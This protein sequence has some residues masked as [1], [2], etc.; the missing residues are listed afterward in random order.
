MRVGRLRIA[1][2]ERWEA[3]PSG[4]L[5]ALCC[6]TGDG[7]DLDGERR[8]LSA[9]DVIFIRA[10]DAVRLR[11]GSGGLG[12]FSVACAGA[13]VA[14]LAR[15]WPAAWPWRSGGPVPRVRLPAPALARLHGWAEILEWPGA[16]ALDRDAFL[17]DLLRLAR[18]PGGWPG[19]VPPWL[20]EALDVFADPHHLPGGIPRLAHLCDRS[21]VH[22]N[23][24][25]RQHLG[26]TATQTVNRIRLAWA[27][28]ALRSSER[29][30]AAIALDCGL[31]ARSQF[32]RMF[33]QAYGMPPHAYRTASRGP[34]P[35]NTWTTTLV[36]DDFATPGWQARWQAL[37]APGHRAFAP[38]HGWLVSACDRAAW[39]LL[40]ERLVP[41]WAVEYEARIL[42][43]AQPGDLSLCWHGGDAPPDAR[44]LGGGRGSG[45]L[46]LQIGAQDNTL[47]MISWRGEHLVRIPH[48]LEPGRTYRIRVEMDGGRVALLLDGR[49]LLA[50]EEAYPFGPGWI[51]LYAY[52]PGKAFRRAS[53]R[54]RW[55]P[56]AIPALTLGDGLIQR[57]LPK[58][59]AEEYRRV[60]AANPG[61]PLGDEAAYKL[62]LALR[63][64]GDHGAAQA[65]WSG[66]REPRLVGAA[67][68]HRAGDV[69]IVDPVAG[70]ACFRAA[71]YDHPSAH[72]ALRLTWS[73]SLRQLTQGPESAA[74]C[75]LL[76]ALKDELFPDDPT[77]ETECSE[78]LFATWRPDAVLV[79]QPRDPICIAYALLALGRF[80]EIPER[81]PAMPTAVR[82]ALL[83]AGRLDELAARFPADPSTRLL[84]FLHKGGAAD[85]GQAEA[86]AILGG[87][88][89]ALPPLPRRP[90][91]AALG[92][93]PAAAAAG[94]PVAML[95]LGRDTDAVATRLDR[96]VLMAWRAIDAADRG[97]RGTSDAIIAALA[98]TPLHAD[99][100]ELWFARQALP[101]ILA[102]L[103]GTPGPLQ[104]A[105]AEAGE[106]RWHWGQRW[107]HAA[108]L[109]SGSIDEHAYS[110][111]PFAREAEATVH[112]MAGIAA[113]LAGRPAAAHRRY[114]TYLALPLWRRLRW[115]LAIDPV[116]E[117]FAVWRSRLTGA[118]N[119]T[120]PRRRSR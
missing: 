68:A 81:L 89:E 71:W 26:Q 51:A 43:G 77:T 9:G 14:H 105:L 101:P 65:A 75:D 31:G 48:S 87:R 66:L 96:R 12:L 25:L 5:T 2:S 61:T 32:Y 97:D 45:A 15:S 4:D 95:M 37:A 91:A 106:I 84:S 118:R 16:D 98:A 19:A 113:E 55:L 103:A 36:D 60:R 47:A 17:L 7:T 54:T 58:E 40:S 35:T 13:S 24:V 39:L 49:P 100:A 22:L 94:H 117:R 28:E 11:A 50:H 67:E 1:P 42:P 29:S 6:L 62:G 76:I 83:A 109:L 52:Y 104:S 92:D 56:Q 79:R 38:L 44:V 74:A 20:G 34:A 46:L 72:A 30:V 93:W 88:S 70:A 119:C 73:R 114:R 63:R 107:W 111:Q 21:P 41:P 10:E 115:D 78:A 99:P 64:C 18:H 3:S 23:R 116:I 27:A 86:C 80:A 85:P 82:L 110:R 8:S 120:P 69:L 90:W 53:V 59:A 112:V 108:R 33:R 102:A 57:G